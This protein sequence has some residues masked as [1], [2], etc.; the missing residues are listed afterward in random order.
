MIRLS[1]VVKNEETRYLTRVLESAKKYI[2]DAVIIDDGSTD[3]T[4]ALCKDLLK[5]VPHTIIENRLSNFHKNEWELRFQQWN[6]TIKNNPDWI[7]FLDADEIFEDSFATGVNDL[8]NVT[9]CDL[10]AFRL[11]DFWDE[12]HYREDSIWRA[13]AI[14]RPFLLRYKKDFPF[15]FKKTTLHSFRMPVNVFELPHRCSKYRLK[16]YGW[17]REEDRI[18]KYNLYLKLDPNGTY[19]SLAQYMSILDPTPNLVKWEENEA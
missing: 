11:Y 15:E 10:Y 8:I 5:T 6:E 9:D 17:A 12:Q 16:H 3:N 18:A 4:V 2:S 1:M 7:I 14:Y 19:G 13:H